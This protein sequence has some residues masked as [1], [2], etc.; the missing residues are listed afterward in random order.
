MRDDKERSGLLVHL[1]AETEAERVQVRRVIETLPEPRLEMVEVALGGAQS[2]GVPEV[3]LVV[4]GANP[5]LA[6]AYLQRW[7]ERPKRPLLVGLQRDGDAALM[8][9]ILHAGADELLPL[10]LEANEAALLFFKLKERQQNSAASGQSGKIYSVAG[11]A[12]GVGMSTIS[13]N[14]A[15]AMRYELGRRVAIVDLD[16][17]N[18]GIALKLHLN[19]TETIVALLECYRRLDSIKLEAALT[20]HPSGIYVMA[21]PKQIEDADLVPDAAVTAVLEL[22]RQLFDAVIVDCGRRINENAVAAWEQSAEVLYVIDQSPWA[23]WRMPRFSEMFAGLG[24]RNVS[25][26]L[27]VNRFD[28]SAGAGIAELAR[29]AGTP[30][31]AVVPRDTR[32]T[33]R[34]QLHPE[35]LWQCAASSRLARAFEKLAH[36]VEAPGQATVRTPGLVARLMSSIGAWA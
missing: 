4:I 31:F 22:M 7:S 3:A 25:P 6:L 19:P 10:P 28:P 5:A 32:T 14:L 9:Q 34:L 1:V 17:Q 16:L 33:E 36:D 35:D 30:V 26:R 27:V 2:G 18:G 8:R 15:L 11:L 23:A 20:K 21:A 29:A 13:A 12:G 24:F